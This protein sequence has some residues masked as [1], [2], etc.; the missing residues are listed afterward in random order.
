MYICEFVAGKL[1][2]LMSH[3]HK[4]QLKASKKTVIQVL[5]IVF[6]RN[7]VLAFSANGSL[8]IKNYL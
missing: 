7:E 8:R 2:D 1:F 5:T 6:N 4:Q 3:T